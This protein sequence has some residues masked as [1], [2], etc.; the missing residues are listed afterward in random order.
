MD[1]RA[2]NSEVVV[3]QQKDFKGVS[4]AGMVLGITSI[5]FA[6]L[7]G[8]VLGILAIIFSIIGLKR[9]KNG[10]A[11]TGLVTGIIGLLLNLAILITVV[12]YIGIQQR[13]QDSSLH[14]SASS[15]QKEAELF[16]ANQGAYPSYDEIKGV[17]KHKNYAFSIDAQGAN[18]NADI[19]YI[20]CYGKG[21]V[22][23]YWSSELSE[24]QTIDVG[25][26]L[27]CEYN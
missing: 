16:N 26:T 4:T 10:L 5:I 20:P 17:L 9:K 22:I 27:D 13:T 23:W 8:F 7:L 24:Y 25:L 12:F 19:V 21:A 3:A 14:A 11:I 15:V 1:E 18:D 2:P 6:F